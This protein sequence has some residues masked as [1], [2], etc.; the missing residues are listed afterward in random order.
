MN[1]RAVLIG[2]KL[3]GDSFQEMQYSIMELQRLAETAGATVIDRVIQSRS[4]I[5]AATFIGKGK[6]EE[7]IQFYSGIDLFIFNHEL[8]PAQVKNIETV[9]QT[10]VV[11]RTELIL[12]IFAIH[13]RSKI[14]RLQVEIAQ[15]KY[16]FPRLTGHGIDMSQIE[17]GIGMRGPGETKLET[18]RRYYRKRIHTLEK[19]LKSIQKAKACQ[20]KQRRNEFKISIIGYT[21]SGKSTLMNQLVKAGI[22]VE[23]RLFATLDTT[24][25]KLWLG[26]NI[27]VLITDTI[28]FIRELPHN[29]V[30]SFKST[31]DEI[32]YSQL[33]LHI[34]DIASPYFRDQLAVVKATVKE[35]GAGNI[36][37]L[38]CFNK[39]D[40]VDTELLVDIRLE[41]PEA[42]YISGL[43]N[44][45]LDILKE[46]IK[47]EVLRQRCIEK[48][49]E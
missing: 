46:R 48:T 19:K 17:G 33:L 31:L 28:G 43:K 21:N 23:D 25:R 1:Q 9:L 40:A 38:L 18:D 29:L 16:Q 41:Y 26:D 44:Q 22:L 35:L 32:R 7:I 49:I 30:E 14:S 12:D 37:C 34:A 20:R 6:L 2:L 10:R 47:Q 3:P 4:K 13:A 42:L 27:K 8:T 36:P 15:L 45:N 5:D 11:T 24:T 39:I